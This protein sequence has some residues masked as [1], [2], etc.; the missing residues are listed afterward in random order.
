MR[1]KAWGLVAVDPTRGCVPEEQSVACR[2][3][4]HVLPAAFAALAWA[5]AAA[6]GPTTGQ[7][8]VDGVA[9]S[10]VEE[11][12]GEPIVFVHGAVSDERAW[13]P[14][15]PEIADRHRF[16]APTLRYFGTRDWPDDGQRFGAA[17]HAQDVAALIE[18]LNL[19]PVH[20]VGWSYGA[21]VATAA[22]LER[23]ELVRTLVLFEPA[24]GA[25]VDEGEPGAAAREDASAMFGPVTEAVEAG[26]DAQ[27]AKLL[28]EGVFQL[29]PGGFDREPPELHAM[30]LE[31]A[32]TMPLL[33]A[34][35]DQ[36]SPVT[37]AKLRRFDRPTLIVYGAETNAFFP[38]IARGMGA[39]LPGAEVTAQPD[40]NHDGPVRDPAGLAAR[41][42]G[43]V[44]QH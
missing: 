22:A 39:C 3:W 8:Q 21:N 20:L 42:E 35:F 40:V 5:G 6:A 44:A 28:I 26:D 33:W 41:I 18:A 13:A 19:G 43:F 7:I 23:P 15:R 17:T 29:P 10:Y 38:A 4:R 37:C 34:A 27:A 24:L 12:T 36:P 31:N 25:F 2:R 9:L 32:R 14:I 30:H 16:I 1:W 11:G